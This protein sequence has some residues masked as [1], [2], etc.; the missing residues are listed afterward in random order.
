MQMVENSASHWKTRVVKTD[1]LKEWWRGLISTRITDEIK[2]KWRHSAERKNTRC[3]FAPYCLLFTTACILAFFFLLFFLLN[4]RYLYFFSK[5]DWESNGGLVKKLPSIREDEENDEEQHSVTRA[6]RSP[7]RLTRGL[8]SPLRSPLLP[9]RPF[10]PPSDHSRPATLQIP[11]VSFSSAPPELS[12]RCEN[13][14][15]TQ[16]HFYFFLSALFTSFWAS[17]WR[18]I[19]LLPSREDQ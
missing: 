2:R 17:F 1:L 11:V 9:P 18:R 3:Y 4:T 15:H 12:P 16:L 5:V 8:N 6:P 14:A 19:L 13:Q 7:L 10:R